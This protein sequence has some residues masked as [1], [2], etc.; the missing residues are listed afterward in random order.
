MVD[1]PGID[2]LKM[3]IDVGAYLEKHKDN[4]IPLLIIPLSGGGT[5]LNIYNGLKRTFKKMKNF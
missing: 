5:E 4:I 1:A 2:D 3:A